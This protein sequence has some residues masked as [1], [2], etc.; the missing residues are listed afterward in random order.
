MK[1]IV[2]FQGC[3]THPRVSQHNLSCYINCVD[4][5]PISEIVHLCPIAPRNVFD[6][7]RLAKCG[8]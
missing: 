1:A 6:Q 3:Q 7:K 2:T 4:F 5:N 8:L